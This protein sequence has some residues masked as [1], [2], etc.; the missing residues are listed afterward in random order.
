MKK[1]IFKLFLILG[2]LIIPLAALQAADIKTNN[3]IYINKDE[4]I[5]GNLYAA[6]NTITVDGNISGDLIA[7]AQTIIV[8]GRIEGDLISLAQEIIINGAVGGN[9]RVAGNS[10][11]INGPVARNVNAFGA[12]ISLGDK[13]HV[14]W[15]VYLAAANCEIRG[16]IDGNLNGYVGQALIAGK[17]GKNVDLT[18]NNQ[19]DGQVLIIA[20][21]TIINGDLIYTA[22]NAANISDKANISG[23]TQ[24]KILETKKA[25]NWFL[26][27]LWSRLFAIFS[28]LA[29]GLVLIFLG[30]NIT[31]K[32]TNK[33]QEA[34]LKVFWSGLIV[35]FVM[36][37]IA[38][39]LLFTLI[40]I[41]LAFMTMTIWL[42]LIY[43]AKIIS[44]LLI[45]QMILDKTTKTKNWK[46]I[47]PLILGVFITWIIFSLPFVGW[48]VGLAAVCFGLGGMW[49][50]LLPALKSS[51][52]K[53]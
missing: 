2:L 15:D 3:S 25:N 39:I 11:V 24:Q 41:P 7:V 27:W 53:L 30:Q 17:I 22:K 47:W 46:P 28:A 33:I 34:P 14:G 1:Q 13:A 32:I 23:Q 6:G 43:L 20:P 10:L 37:P 5:A 48:L 26:A 18:F 49:L 36:P 38:L 35:L 29:V 12:K 44:A 9:I 4:I 50:C 51:E 45:G 52:S 31:S 42:I 21:E 40:G 8:N 16:S 19:S